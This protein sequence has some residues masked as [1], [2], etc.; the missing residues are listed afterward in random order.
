MIDIDIDIDSDS[1]DDRDPYIYY[2]ESIQ[3]CKC[4][5]FS[6]ENYYN[7]FKRLPYLRRDYLM[8]L[9]LKNNKV[10]YKKVINTYEKHKYKYLLP[11]IYYCL[12]Y[13]NQKPIYDNNLNKYVI[14]PY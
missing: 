3:I 2:N 13:R 12:Y 4:M 7:H 1:D 9:L 11:K 6:I 5:I 8:F 14:T 10:S